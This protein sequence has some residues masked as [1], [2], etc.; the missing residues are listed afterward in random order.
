MIE[1]VKKLLNFIKIT[2]NRIKISKYSLA[3]LFVLV[4]NVLDV[5]AQNLKPAITGY[6][7][8]PW[9]QKKEFV[10]VINDVIAPFKAVAVF[11]ELPNGSV[12]QVQKLDSSEDYLVTNPSK[13]E[14]H[15]LDGDGYL[16]LTFLND[17]KDLFVFFNNGHGYFGGRQKFSPTVKLAGYEI[18]DFNN[19]GRLDIVC[20]DSGAS[21]VTKRDSIVTYYQNLGRREFAESGRI[22]SYKS[23]GVELLDNNNDGFLDLFFTV[24]DTGNSG[25]SAAW[26]FNFNL[27]NFLSSGTTYH[28]GFSIDSH[29]PWYASFGPRLNIPSHMRR[30]GDLNGDGA[31]DIFMQ[32]STS[33]LGWIALSEW[34]LDHYDYIEN[35][36]FSDIDSDDSS[37]LNAEFGDF[38]NDG[39][40]DTIV[41]GL[42]NSTGRCY[43]RFVSDYPN[44]VTHLDFRQCA[45]TMTKVHIDDDSL[46]DLAVYAVNE[47]IFYKNL[48]DGTFSQIQ[49]IAVPENNNG[50]NSHAKLSGF[51]LGT[52]SSSYRPLDFLVQAGNHYSVVTSNG[53][54][55]FSDLPA[56]NYS[57]SAFSFGYQFDLKNVSYNGSNLERVN[58]SARKSSAKSV[59]SKPT[60]TLWNG[61]LDMDNILELINIGDSLMTVNVELYSIEGNLET[62]QYVYIPA[63]GQFDLIL[64]DLPGFKKNSYGIIKINFDGEL[65][66]RLFY[67]KRDIAEFEFAFAMPLSSPS[68]GRKYVSF[69]TYNPTFNSGE[70]ANLV[71]NWL[72]IVNLSNS[73][74]SYIVKKYGHA[75]NLLATNTYLVPAFGRTDLESGHINPGPNNVGQNEIIPLDE[76]APYLA[77]LTR[78]GDALPPGSVG[79][80]FSFAT[81]VE[82]K[83]PSSAETVLSIS[84]REGGDNWVE[85]INTLDQNVNTSVWFFNSNGSN[86]G[87]E[88]FVLSPYAQKHIWVPTYL[89]KDDFGFAVVVPGVSNSIIAQSMN[90]FRGESSGSI[91]GVYTSQGRALGRSL[92]FGS[93][94]LYLGMKNYLRISNPWPENTN[95]LLKI[96]PNE[97]VFTMPIS[98]FGTI[99]VPLHNT[100]IFGTNIN[101]YKPFYLGLESGRPAFSEL[102]R[103]KPDANSKIDFASPTEVR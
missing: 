5:S 64:N 93:Y 81:A 86:V 34:H 85:I 82:S 101:S 54:Y 50:N 87:F 19:D 56:G 76:N 39:K 4:F 15:D 14:L 78:Y 9:K 25:S 51:A 43:I 27:G 24:T 77:L 10:V 32:S 65:D 102:V 52:L 48:G 1:V 38:N 100:G 26:T 68:K 53:R 92:V 95:V 22:E 72:S 62:S 74:K 46:L 28:G 30:V 57:V 3:I 16:D 67:Y 83:S 84:R 2:Q 71:Y 73:P 61:F 103:I 8:F 12:A 63:Q 70:A 45:F 60:Y 58:L 94:N 47:V 11:H 31:D 96:S 7:D 18:A 55:V 35:L 20:I 44:S 66:G 75:G 33:Y 37:I 13:V 42:T 17:E 21:A 80:N 69:N 41:S 40:I 98:A 6:V 29:R 97:A 88:E 49:K 91:L 59:L 90:Y 99:E 79:A 89:S 36:N 23:L